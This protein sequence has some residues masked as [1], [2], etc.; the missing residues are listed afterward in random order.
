MGRPKPLWTP[1][2]TPEYIPGARVGV[3]PFRH[4]YGPAPWSVA[5]IPIAA[6]WCHPCL[7]PRAAEK[8]L[9][10]SRPSA[11]VRISKTR[12]ESS[13]PRRRLPFISRERHGR[14]VR[15][16]EARQLRACARMKRMRAIRHPPASD[17]P[18]SNPERRTPWSSRRTRW[19]P[20]LARCGRS[21]GTRAAVSA[22]VA[23]HERGVLERAPQLRRRRRG[24]PFFLGKETVSSS[25]RRPRTSS[26]P[27]ATDFQPRK[28]GV[29]RWSR[30]R[31]PRSMRNPR[32]RRPTSAG[33][34]FTAGGVERRLSPDG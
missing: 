24:A 16:R 5:A 12:A 17:G 6:L 28:G 22:A 15:C 23:T 1:V 13:P 2:P 7:D 19:L 29:R 18:A 21:D 4:A 10:P 9:P 8:V 11:D 34:T 30:R 33:G 25:R 14:C 26:R 31:R 3:L 20:W 32:R 27:A